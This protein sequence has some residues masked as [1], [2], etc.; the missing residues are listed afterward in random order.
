MPLSICASPSRPVITPEFTRHHHPGRPVLNQMAAKPLTICRFNIAYSSYSY[1]EPRNI[2][3]A[4]YF[5]V[6]VTYS[7]LKTLVTATDFLYLCLRPLQLLYLLSLAKWWET[8]VVFTSP[9]VITNADKPCGKHRP[10]RTRSLN[11]CLKLA[12]TGSVE[13]TYLIICLLF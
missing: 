7:F 2:S 1:H 6:Y 13:R 4:P 11:S 10:W 5:S 3:N 8:C 12:H 9:C